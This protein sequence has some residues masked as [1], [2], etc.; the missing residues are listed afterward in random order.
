MLNITDHVIIVIIHIQFSHFGWRN[1]KNIV[2]DTSRINAYIL[3]ANLYTNLNRLDEAMEMYKKALQLSPNNAQTYM[4]LGNAHYL[5]SDIEKAISSYRAAI[6]IEP[7]NDEHK[8][9]YYQVMDEYIDKKRR[10]ELE[11]K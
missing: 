1:D 11:N 3:L 5:Q 2:I 9:V 6:K 7:D 10:G 4:L 8:L